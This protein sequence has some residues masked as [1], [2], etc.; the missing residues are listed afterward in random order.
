MRREKVMEELEQKRGKIRELGVE[1]LELAGSHVKDTA[2]EESDIDFIVTFKAGRGGY[3]DYFDLLHL[4]EDVFEKE[5]DLAKK[6][7][8]KEELKD[9]LL[10]DAVDTPV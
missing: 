8:I 6:E 9:S 2:D 5:I 10:G 1:R 3:R 4:L 7:L